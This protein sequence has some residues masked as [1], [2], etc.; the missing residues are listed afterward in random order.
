MRQKGRADIPGLNVQ[1]P[2]SQLITSGKKIVETRG[3]T[4][5]SKHLGKEIALIETPGPNGKKAAGIVKARIIGTVRFSESFRY[6]TKA[7]WL[8]DKAR[9]CV[10]PNDD[11]FKFKKEKP[12]WGWVISEVRILEAPVAAPKSRGIIFSKFC[13]IPHDANFLTSL[14]TISESTKAASITTRSSL[15]RP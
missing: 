15:L 2:W 12:K 13:R 3:Y 7:Q 5:P 14:S 4:L 6:K 11:L 9:H 1:W 10:S 8:S